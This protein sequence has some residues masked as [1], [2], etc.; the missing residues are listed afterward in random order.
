[1]DNVSQ[2]QVTNPTFSIKDWVS[3]N[4]IIHVNKEIGWNENGYPFV[5]FINDQNVAE[6]VYFSK[7]QAEKLNKGDVLVKGF[8]N[9]KMMTL[10]TNAEGEKRLKISSKSENR[11]DIGD[12]L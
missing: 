6:N 12:I 1:M 8:F 4:N 7:K 3:D 2:E 9:D 5:T 10:T 11:L